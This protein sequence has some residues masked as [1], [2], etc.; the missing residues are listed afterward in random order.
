MTTGDEPTA[1]AAAG[2]DSLYTRQHERLVTA[3]VLAGSD[4]GTAEDLAH[5]AFVRVLV[6]WRRVRDPDGYLYRTAFRLRRRATRRTAL[7]ARI[8]VGLGPRPVAL[9][10]VVLRQAAVDHLL[11]RLPLRQRECVVLV[12]YLGCSTDEAASRL[13]IRPS[14]VRVHLHHARR[15]LRTGDMEPIE[16]D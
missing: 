16:I 4:Q 10:E 13:G 1:A 15:A 3:L 11:A 9:E 2:F 8:A 6:A 12:F 5:E 14:T 7:G